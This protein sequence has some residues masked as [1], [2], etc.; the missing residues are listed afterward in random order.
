[1]SESNKIN[2]T[3]R[4]SSG[5]KTQVKVKFENPKEK[6]CSKCGVIKLAIEFAIRPKNG[7]LNSYCK[8]CG[9]N[10]S[11]NWKRNNK[12]RTNK[13]THDWKKDNKKHVTEYNRV[14]GNE[15]KKKDPNFRI[16]TNMRSRLS[17][18]LKSIK[19]MKGGDS[20]EKSTKL[21][22]CTYKFLYKWIEYRLTGDMTMENYGKT[23][24][25]D[26]VIPCASFDLT[27]EENRL[28][29]FNWK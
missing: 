23:W 16:R 4:K 9:R 1:M 2:L 3:K 6:E 26:H 25:I 10:M 17:C 12:E 22:G 15:R 27:K 20:I 11:N 8:Q 28:K 5:S 7:K 29:C 19:T 24:H 13:Y 14:Y 18:L 21:L